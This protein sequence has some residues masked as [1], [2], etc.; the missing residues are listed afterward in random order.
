MLNTCRF[1]VEAGAD[2]VV[3]CHQHCYSGYEIYKGKPIFYG[4]GNLCFDWNGRRK[5]PWN[6]GF[7]L[8]LKL[9]KGVVDFKLIPYIQADADPGIRLM[10]G[11]Q[12]ASFYKSIDKLNDAITHSEELDKQHQIMMAKTR[13]EYYGMLSPFS[14][15]LMMGLYVRG[16]LPR[17]LPKRKFISILNRIECESHRERFIDMLKSKIYNE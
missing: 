13:K 4:L 12:K 5:S 11:E 1:F 16:Y 9:D 3:N 8:L 15:R 10:K 17:W 14:S 7:L 2:V 6:E